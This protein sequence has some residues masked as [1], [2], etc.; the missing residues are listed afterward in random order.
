MDIPYRRRKIRFSPTKWLV[1]HFGYLITLMSESTAERETMPAQTDSPLRTA[2]DDPAGDNWKYMAPMAV[3]RCSVAA[4][5][6]G[7]KRHCLPLT[8]D[9]LS[10]AFFLDLPLAFHYLQVRSTQSAAR[11]PQPV[12]AVPAVGPV[13]QKHAR[14]HSTRHKH[15]RMHS[16]RPTAHTRA[17]TAHTHTHTRCTQ[18][19]CTAVLELHRPFWGARMNRCFCCEKAR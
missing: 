14:L 5:A 12:P 6:L 2:A 9:Y 19:L 17:R 8:F 16:T 13:T 15:A 10:T 7:S 11:Q 3:G 1:D 4:A 18:P